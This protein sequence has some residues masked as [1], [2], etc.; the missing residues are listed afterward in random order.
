LD[1]AEFFFIAENKAPEP[2]DLRALEPKPFFKT[3]QDRNP[4][5]RYYTPSLSLSAFSDRIEE[6][7]NEV[8]KG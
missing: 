6:R 8:E 7:S 3:T 2:F 5:H 4:I 1:I